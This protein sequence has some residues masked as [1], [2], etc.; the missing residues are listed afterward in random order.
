[1]MWKRQG[2]GGL[3]QKVLNSLTEGEIPTRSAHGRKATAFV[4]NKVGV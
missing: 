1:M 4:P 2:K 3:A